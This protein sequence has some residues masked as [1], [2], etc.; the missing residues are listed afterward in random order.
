MGSW[1]GQLGSVLGHAGPVKTG[2]GL[3]LGRRAWTYERLRISALE[4]GIGEPRAGGVIPG[5]TGAA[6]ALDLPSGVAF[7]CA[8][9][10]A[11][12]VAKEA[13]RSR[14]K[15]NPWFG[16]TT[17]SSCGVPGSFLG[18]LHILPLL[19]GLESKTELG[20]G[21]HSSP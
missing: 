10:E 13:F 3:Q 6:L 2:S 1:A 4:R 19:P 5:R 15:P 16:S 12:H 21:T 17:P 7:G 11:A 18:S 9:E 8:L 14:L 20:P